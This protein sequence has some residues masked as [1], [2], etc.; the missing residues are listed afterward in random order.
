MGEV[1]LALDLGGAWR[2]EVPERGDDDGEE[3]VAPSG[4]DGVGGNGRLTQ[5][6]AGI[7]GGDGDVEGGVFDDGA[8]GRGEGRVLVT[9][10]GARDETATDEQGGGEG[11][12]GERAEVFF[13]VVEEG[14]GGD[15]ERV[16][17]VV[18]GEIVGERREERGG[19]I[20]CGSR[21]R[22]GGNLEA[23]GTYNCNGRG[24]GINKRC[25]QA[26]P[27]GDGIP[28]SRVGD[29]GG[30]EAEA[31]SAEDA[32]SVG[33]DG[34]RDNDSVRAWSAATEGPVQVLVLC[35]C[36]DEALPLS[37]DDFPLENLVRTQSVQG[38]QE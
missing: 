2:R 22:E 35:G 8:E 36:G 12:K 19:L 33:S 5:R 4:Q 14:E 23:G 16:G 24:T 31:C 28:V 20:D 25:L 9:D 38:T 29:A 27:V 21:G 1:V 37:S 17:Y 32:S 10:D 6:V 3:G 30:S 13:V 18:G 11:A 15:V 26:L 34:E 7:E